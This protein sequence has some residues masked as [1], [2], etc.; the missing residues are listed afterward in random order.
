LDGGWG[1]FG[2]ELFDVEEYSVYDAK[3]EICKDGE[4]QEIQH[5]LNRDKNYSINNCLYYTRKQI[6]ESCIN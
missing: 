6:H 4:D 2:E 5:E 3:D 1:I